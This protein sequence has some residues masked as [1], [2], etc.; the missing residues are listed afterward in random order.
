[1]QSHAQKQ[2]QNNQGWLEAL[3]TLFAI[4]NFE[5]NLSC[6][7]CEL[8]NR[9]VQYDE[10]KFLETLKEFQGNVVL[11]GGEPLL[12]RKRLYKILETGKIDSISTNLLLLDRDI[13]V[14]FRDI[15]IA[16]TWTPGRF[17]KEE[18][19]IW[20]EKLEILS[21]FNIDTKLLVTL[22]ED[23]V[24]LEP[25]KVYDF[26]KTLEKFSISS[27]LFEQLLDNS[28]GQEYYEKVDLWLCEIHKLFSNL[29]FINEIEAEIKQGWDFDCSDTYTLYPD[30]IIRRY[31][32]Q[33]STFQI[34]EMC[35]KCERN[36]ECRPCMLQN[37]CV[38]PKN[39][40]NLIFKEQID[41]KESN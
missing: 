25:I 15:N 28:K 35:Y 19:D 39:L 13:A 31:C 38:F 17:N 33:F 16:T 22:S 20:L 30:G 2:G 3:K 18:L 14:K 1:M 11:F 7:Y 5:C 8:K 37:K 4:P 27:V 9:R 34:N 41:T 21:E 23:T 24:A 10:E 26:L 36:I 12:F 29:R 32:P 6:G 40:G